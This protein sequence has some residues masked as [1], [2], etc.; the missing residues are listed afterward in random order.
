MVP[1]QKNVPVECH[2]WA[3]SKEGIKWEDRGLNHSIN[4][5]TGQAQLDQLKPRADIKRKPCR[6]TDLSWSCSHSWLI[7]YV[8]EPGTH[9]PSPPSYPSCDSPFLMNV[10]TKVRRSSVSLS[11][12]TASHWKE[13]PSSHVTTAVSKLVSDLDRSPSMVSSE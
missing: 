12:L 6:R 2:R 5:S 10:E 9:Y 7:E 1:A 8:P 3:M 13:L 4:E 11:S